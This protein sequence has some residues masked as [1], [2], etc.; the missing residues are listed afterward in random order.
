[1]RSC[2]LLFYSTIFVILKLKIDNVL[3]YI[4]GVNSANF[5]NF[6]KKSPNFQY[7]KIEEKQWCSHIASIVRMPDTRSLGRLIALIGVYG[8]QS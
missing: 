6:W 2:P 8:F 3:K 5:V 7:D 4:S 1:M